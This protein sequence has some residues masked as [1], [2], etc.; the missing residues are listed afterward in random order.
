[1]KV[2]ILDGEIS[3]PSSIPLFGSQLTG[4]Q[5]FCFS[6]GNL[7]DS[8]LIKLSSDTD[9]GD[10]LRKIAGSLPD[11]CTVKPTNQKAPPC[12]YHQYFVLYLFIYFSTSLLNMIRQ[13]KPIRHLN[14]SANGTSK[15][16]NKHWI[17]KGIWENRP[18]HKQLKGNKQTIITGSMKSQNKNKGTLKRTFREWE[19][20]WEFKSIRAEVKDKIEGL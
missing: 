15:D 13:P 16:W 12:T 5:H 17:K 6:G 1:M 3:K 7:E 20:C 19:E 14:K 4:S 10:P 9:F 8:S 11:C 2:Y 18:E